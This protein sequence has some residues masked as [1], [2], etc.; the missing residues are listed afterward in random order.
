[1]KDG[2][3]N[4]LMSLLASGLNGFD[5]TLADSREVLAE[6]VGAAWTQVLGLSEILKPFC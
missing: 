2:V 4:Y 5:K 6:P 1:M 3:L